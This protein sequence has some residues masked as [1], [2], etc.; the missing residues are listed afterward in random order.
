MGLFGDNVSKE[1]RQKQKQQEHFQK[2]IAKYHLQGISPSLAPQINEIAL[3]LSGNSMIE[4]GT[5]FQGN[6]TD[7]AKLSYMNAIVKQNF[8][9]IKLLDQIANK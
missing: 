2:I 1:E 7:S 9:I 8:M 5:L 4:L 3:E 6:S